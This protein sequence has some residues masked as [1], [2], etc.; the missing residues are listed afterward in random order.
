MSEVERE[1]RSVL[2]RE[3]LL[4]EGGP[5]R[6]KLC[7]MSRERDIAAVN[8]CLPDMVG[9]VCDFPTSRRS[10]PSG[11]MGRLAG[12]VSERVYT[13]GVSV[14]LPFG[15]VAYNANRHVDIV[16]LHGH[17]DATYISGL[18]TRMAGGIIQAF[19]IRSRTDVERALASPADMVLLDAGQ[20]SGTTFDWSLVE[21]F[22][23]RR[24]FILAGGLTPSNVAEAIAALHPWGVDM[25]SGVETDGS[26]DP[27]K[28]AAAVAAV[29]RTHG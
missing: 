19:R 3:F 11:E 16:Q 8:A 7:G 13:V 28:M 18:R 14:D 26:K 22:G 2:A 9:F 12:Q 10:V 21:G 27:N 25:S 6:I 20:G 1:A 23:D 17:E 4:H 5:C 24:P 29:R 15:R